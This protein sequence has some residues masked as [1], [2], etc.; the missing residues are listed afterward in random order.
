[1][2]NEDRKATDE[3]HDWTRDIHKETGIRRKKIDKKRN[4]L[5][6]RIIS[7]ADA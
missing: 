2:Y 1:M 5:M 3:Q 7:K 4:R 6:N